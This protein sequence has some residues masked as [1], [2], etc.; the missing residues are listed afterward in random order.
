MLKDFLESKTKEELK[1]SAPLSDP[2]DPLDLHFIADRIV[3]HGFKEA[4]GW[5]EAPQGLFPQDGLRYIEG[6][7]IEHGPVYYQRGL[8]QKI[9]DHLVFNINNNIPSETTTA[10]RDIL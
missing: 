1:R 9:T 6:Y 3:K 2:N 10:K 7:G 8:A 5:D 4:T